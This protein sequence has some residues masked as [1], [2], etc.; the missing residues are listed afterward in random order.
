V[1]GHYRRMIDDPVRIAA[2]ER[3]IR[4][5]VRPGTVV[6][7]LGCAFGNYAV[8]ACLAG[9]RKVYAVEAGAVAGVARQVAQANGFG[10][11]IEVLRGL[12]TELDPPERADVVVYEDYPGALISPAAARTNRDAVERW[13]VPGGRM[14]PQRGRLWVAPVEAREIHAELDRFRDSGERVGGVDI[15]PT[16]RLAFSETVPVH[17]T[18]DALLTEPQLAAEIGLQPLGDPGLH[19]DTDAK[20]TR[21][22]TIHGL[23]LWF[24]MELAG[25]WLSSGPLAPPIA[26]RQVLFP[27]ESPV[28][29]EAGQELRLTLDG[30]AFGDEMVWRWGVETDEESRSAD[31]L[32]SASLD[33]ERLARWDPDR[34]PRRSPEHELE[35]AVLE[36]IDGRRSLERIASE[37]EERFPGR[38]VSS[39]LARRRV[40]EVLERSTRS[41]RGPGR[42]GHPASG[43]ETSWKK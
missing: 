25:E 22:G 38:F 12:S 42:P 3:A 8:L 29:V 23:L 40:L 7:D 33:P 35:L 15:A 37:L 1:I 41:G 24:E 18:Q 11:R 19:F 28:A 26:W 4:A 14:I 2:F 10:D 9:A 32:E 13:L 30:G 27:I 21:P 36:L 5:A 6:V 39:E 34:V 43:E 20:T 16:R 31:N 17:L